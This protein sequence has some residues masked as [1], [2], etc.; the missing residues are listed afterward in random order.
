VVTATIFERDRRANVP[1]L[2]PLVVVDRPVL[3]V[4]RDL[5]H[6]PMGVP[7]VLGDQARQELFVSDDAGRGVDGGDD[8]GLPAIDPDVHLV[9]E[10]GRDLRALDDGRV[11]IRAAHQPIVQQPQPG[12]RRVIGAG[13]VQ[14]DSLAGR[15]HGLSDRLGRAGFLA[16]CR[17]GRPRGVVRCGRIHTCR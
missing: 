17:A 6:P 2:Q 9:I 12:V 10:V 8:A 15:V 5:E 16:V 11:R 14:V 7:F 1:L 3:G 4:G 13:D